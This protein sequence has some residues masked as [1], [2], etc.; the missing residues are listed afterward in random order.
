MALAGGAVGGQRGGVR[1]ALAGALEA[2]DAGRA[3]ADHRAVE[4]RDRDDRVVEGRLDVDV[5]LGHVL[6]LPATLLDG[7]LPF[8]HALSSPSFTFL[9]PHADRLLRSA[10]LAGVGL[11]PLAADR[12]VAS[13]TQTPVRADLDEALD[14]ERHL[15]AQVA[16]DL[17]ASVDEL[18]QAV[19]LL[20][21]QIADAG[22]RVDVGLRRGSSGWWAA[23]SRRCR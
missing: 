22:V 8:R 21:G 7:P 11:G 5:P 9:A 10:P 6:L 1:R 4:V 23:R 17:V 3:P 2:G 12:Q 16:L 19:D 20:L 13:M 15:A 14:V 18:A